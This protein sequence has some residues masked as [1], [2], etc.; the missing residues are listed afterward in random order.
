MDERIRFTRWNWSRIFPGL[1]L[2]LLIL[3]IGLIHFPIINKAD[4]SL[5]ESSPKSVLYLPAL[6]MHFVYEN[7]ECTNKLLKAMNITNVR[8]GNGS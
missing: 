6:P 2:A 7:P 4:E 3:T 8:I 5:A 1:V